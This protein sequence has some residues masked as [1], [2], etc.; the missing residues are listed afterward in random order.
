MEVNNLV[1]SSR[2]RLARNIDGIPFQTKKKDAFID[3]AKAVEKYFGFYTAE[4]AALNEPLKLALF[5]QHLISKDLTLNVANGIIITNKQN[6]VSVMLGEEDHIRIQ[7]I[8]NGFNLD[9]IF[10]IANSIAEMLENNFNIA[11][12]PNLG[13]I[14]S[15]P[16]NLGTG[17]RAS[18][19]ICLPAL[20]ISG[21]IKTLKLPKK[22]TIRGAYGEGSENEGG[23]YQISNQNTIMETKDEI[24]NKVFFT[25]NDIVKTEYDAQQ[26]L[27][28]QNQDFVID[29]VM[30]AWGVLTNAYL[31]GSKEAGKN[32]MWLKLGECLGI[33]KFKNKI[34]DEL[35][36]KIKPATILVKDKKNI[37]PL[38]RDKFR[39]K[40]IKEKL[41]QNKI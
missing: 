14:T 5:E 17:M 39:A 36:F 11:K 15:C 18:V 16:T 26:A 25:I 4:I 32:L 37:S 24:I 12:S 27:F 38:E 40:E 21:Q 31:I 19:M 33:L 30:R 7:A 20:T 3:V 41:L 34:V 13:Y 23:I 22:I 10:D 8:S 1:I 9:S 35:F 28:L 2:I 6:N 29:N